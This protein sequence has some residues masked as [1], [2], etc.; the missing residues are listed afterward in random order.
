MRASK[1]AVVIIR[2]KENK[3]AGLAI[4]NKDTRSMTLF[5]CEEYSEDDVMFLINGNDVIKA[6]GIRE[7]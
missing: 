7:S 3:V 1:E 5:K 4:R 6:S 2:N